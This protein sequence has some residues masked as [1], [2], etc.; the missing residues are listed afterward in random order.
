MVARSVV[1][2]LK[3]ELDAAND[4][5]LHMMLPNDVSEGAMRFDRCRN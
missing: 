3:T 1:G 2:A 5:L 4:I